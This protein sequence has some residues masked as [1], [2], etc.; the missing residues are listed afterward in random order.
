[1]IT[2]ISGASAAVAVGV[3]VWLV[4]NII[5]MNKQVRQLEKQK[6]QL[7]LGIQGRCDSIERDL[8][9]VINELNG[10]V[11]SSISYTDSR[12][13]KLVNHIEHNYVTKKLIEHDYVTKKNRLD[14]TIDYQ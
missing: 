1:M 12:L 13:D 6:E 8:N 11:D 14:N 5:K 3:I 10:R 9:A 2:F 4:V 7:W